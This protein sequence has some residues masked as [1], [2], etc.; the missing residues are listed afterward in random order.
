VVEAA[1]HHGGGVD[2]MA[3]EAARYRGTRGGGACA[4]SEPGGGRGAGQ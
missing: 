4:Q 2:L 3:V 1:W